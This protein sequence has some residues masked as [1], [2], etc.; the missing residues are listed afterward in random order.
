MIG[1]FMGD[2]D[3]VD[4]RLTDTAGLK[5]ADD[6]FAGKTTVNQDSGFAVADI[7][8]VSTRTAAEVR[9]YKLGHFWTG[10]LRK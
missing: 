5:T 3:G 1:V 6:L 9:E 10:V 7:S 2:Q 8:A 4:S